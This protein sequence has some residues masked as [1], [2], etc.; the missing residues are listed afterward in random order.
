VHCVC[1]YMYIFYLL[2][3]R[4][5]GVFATHLYYSKKVG[6]AQLYNKNS[7][8]FGS[9]I[10]FSRILMRFL[11]IVKLIYFNII[12]VG[13]IEFTQQNNFIFHLNETAVDSL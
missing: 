2:D 1:K 7:S 8:F 4:T 3:K 11:Q 6:V 13:W 10:R 9:E 12:K 5:A